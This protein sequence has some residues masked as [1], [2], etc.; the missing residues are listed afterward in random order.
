MAVEEQA[1][2]ACFSFPVD[3]SL[4]RLKAERKPPLLRTERNNNAACVL[5]SPLDGQKPQTVLNA[6]R[7]RRSN[8]HEHFIAS[9]SPIQ[10]HVCSPDLVR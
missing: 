2:E 4:L 1:A 10:T 3:L 5:R 9:E 7:N 8:N 6:L